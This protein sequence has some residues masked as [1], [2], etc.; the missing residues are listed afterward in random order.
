MNRSK[1]GDLRKARSK[2]FT[3]KFSARR[4]SRGIPH[5]YV[6]IIIIIQPRKFLL[7]DFDRVKDLRYR[8]RQVNVEV[9]III[10]HI[11][12]IFFVLYYQVWIRGCPKIN[13]YNVI[14][15]FPHI[16][17]VL[18]YRVYQNSVIKLLNTVGKATA[19]KLDVYGAG[20]WMPLAASS[21]SCPP[22]PYRFRGPHSPLS[23]A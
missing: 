10:P 1:W 14:K 22:R 15:I 2:D 13:I 11:N 18:S 17:L 19:Y 16:V 6:I 21:F 4:I 8:Y 20:V 5:Q 9:L 23:N 12:N 3:K 7:I